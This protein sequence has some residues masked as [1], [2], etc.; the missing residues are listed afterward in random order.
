MT[1]AAPTLMDRIVHFGRIPEPIAGVEDA[2]KVPRVLAAALALWFCGIVPFYSVTVQEG[3]DAAP[4]VGLYLTL[5]PVLVAGYVAARRT[6]QLVGF[7]PLAAILWVTMLGTV[8]EF[9]LA[10]AP[11]IALVLAATFV[12]WMGTRV[13]P[14]YLGV[15]VGGVFVAGL[16]ASD[17]YLIDRL[18][19]VSLSCAFVVVVVGQRSDEVRQASADREV[20]LA[21]LAHESRHDNLTGLGNRAVLVEELSAL[22]V[23][24][25]RAS[26]GLALV[27]LDLFKQI[28]DEHGHLTG[29]E[30]LI[31]VGRRLQTFALD[32]GTAVRIG[33]DEF[34]VLINEP[35]TS[36]AGLTSELEAALRWSSVREG[37]TIDVGAS[38]GVSVRDRRSAT[39]EGLFSAADRA[40]YERK[41]ER[42]QN[43]PA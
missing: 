16:V 35:A 30:V 22:L 28:N 23:D 26:V 36:P 5:G 14:Q 41:A 6:G 3:L 9:Y 24:K 27:D 18:V 37:R 4:A 42:R 33:G 1:A 40:M 43:E 2:E 32:R 8:S 20:L 34:A 10:G 17:P 13:A 29:D 7:L 38:V 39:L 31:E 15:T 12:S 19:L 11:M 21:R 25:R